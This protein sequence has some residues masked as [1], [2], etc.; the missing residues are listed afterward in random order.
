MGNKSP[1]ETSSQHLK[2]RLNLRSEER[3]DGKDISLPFL[4]TMQKEKQK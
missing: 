3:T 4:V 2:K 1:R